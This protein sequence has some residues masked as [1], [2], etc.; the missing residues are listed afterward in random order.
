MTA[1]GNPTRLSA[2]SW[3]GRDF[4]L[5][6]YRWVAVLGLLLDTAFALV[7]LFSPDAL[8]L[9]FG[10][11]RVEFSYVWLG[12]LAVLLLARGLFILAVVRDPV[13][14]RAYA[15]LLVVSH[16][17]TAVYWLLVVM[18]QVHG[19]DL[20]ALRVVSAGIATIS[21]A[22]LAVPDSQFA[23]AADQFK[24]GAIGLGPA[25]R[26][27][28][29]V[30]EVMP[31]LCPQELGDHANGWATFGLLYEA[32]HDTPIGFAHREIGYPA[33]EPNCSLCHTAS[34]RATTSDV[35]RV[36]PGGPAH[37]LDLERFQRFLY[38]CSSDPG[39]T[40]AAVVQA[41]RKRH[42]LGPVEALVYRFGIVPTLQSGL[43]RQ[44][45]DYAW[46]D[47]RPDQG[48]GRT[49]TFNPTK[50]NV[51]HFSDDGTIGTTDLPAVWNQAPREHLWLH[52]DGNNDQI[53]ER[54]FAAAMAVGA[55]PQSVDT[56]S[57]AKVT[58]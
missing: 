39:F 15:W 31:E 14:L 26:I 27:P 25:S 47:T 9:V 22:L 10:V 38:A 41:I 13:R 21:A 24:Y 53:R 6:L 7:A 58:D 28:Y 11:E 55:T 2:A 49:D 35:S 12:N 36:I 51:F 30:W 42:A 29:Y 57:F 52:W 3:A 45:R 20:S 44:K 50:I 40:G 19:G 17:L 4:A 46:Q 43:A 54:N 16:A 23:S 33:L 18:G 32:G 8:G 37:R 48:R 1:A 56:Q 5:S 34:Y